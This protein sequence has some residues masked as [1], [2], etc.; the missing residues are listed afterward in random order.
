MRT[1]RHRPHRVLFT[2][3]FR[4]VPASVAFASC[5]RAN[6][7]GAVND[8]SCGPSLGCPEAQEHRARRR[9]ARWAQWARLGPQDL[10]GRKVFQVLPDQ[11]DRR[12]RPDPL[13]QQDPS[14]QPG[15]KVKLDRPGHK[16][17]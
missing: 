16:V 10:R 14:E 1:D 9:L 13:D 11:P 4:V 2:P 5:R 17:K 7:A 6:L 15:R 8:A 3:V 12:D